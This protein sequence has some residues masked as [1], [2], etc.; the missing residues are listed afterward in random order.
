M[1]QDL[2]LHCTDWLI[3]LVL[4]LPLLL[5]TNTFKAFLRDATRRC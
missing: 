3:W 2:S 5:G 1:G 4:G